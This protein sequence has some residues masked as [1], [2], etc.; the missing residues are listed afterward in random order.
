MKMW[1]NSANLD[2]EQKVELVS[3]LSQEDR[4]LVDRVVLGVTVAH[5][6]AGDPWAATLL[7]RIAEDVVVRD[8]L[9]TFAHTGEGAR[10][11]LGVALGLSRMAG[12]ADLTG[13]APL[14]VAGWCALSL[15]R[16][17]SA[18]L[19]GIWSLKACDTYSLGHLIRQLIAERWSSDLLGIES[20][21]TQAQVRWCS[22]KVLRR[23]TE[24]RAHLHVN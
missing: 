17:E 20:N 11:V 12:K 22:A 9:C 4:T 14:A 5:K 21:V 2:R 18:D 15:G 3:K 7:R 24:P 16:W 23:L 1:D 8:Y 19:L 6:I 13:A 10:R